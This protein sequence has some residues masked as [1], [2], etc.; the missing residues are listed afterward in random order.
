MGVFA[1][2]GID[3][4]VTQGDCRLHEGWGWE[5]WRNGVGGGKFSHILCLISFF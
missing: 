4:A 5:D 2:A 1:A 3:G